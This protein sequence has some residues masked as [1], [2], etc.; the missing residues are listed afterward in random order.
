MFTQTLLLA[1]ATASFV[2]AHGKVAVVTGDLGGN[3][4][5]LGIKGGVVPGP[6]P[7]YETEVDTTVFWSKDIATDD[8]IGYTEDGSGN[9]QLSDLT[10]AMALSGSTLPQVSSGGSVNGTFHIVTSDGAG[11]LQALVDESATGKWS[12]AKSATVSTQVP[13]TDGNVVTK[14]SLLSRALIKMGLITARAT[15]VNED[16]AFAVDI[17]SGTSCTG[18]INGISNLCL[19]KVSNN[20]ANGPFGG[21]F[22]VQ[23]SNSTTARVKRSTKFTS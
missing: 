8:D 9:N 7:N 5:A 11:P 22:A 20:N 21:V 19:V 13:G 17:P 16:H 14:R 1:L 3:G 15:N 4:T 2:S 10:Q 12:T 6:G 23:M 18:T